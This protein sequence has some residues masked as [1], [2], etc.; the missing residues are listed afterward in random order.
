MLPSTMS[1]F[2]FDVVRIFI[3]QSLSRNPW[4]DY[5]TKLFWVTRKDVI[6]LAASQHLDRNERFRL[7]SLCE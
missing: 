3:H 5:W 7:Y 2:F 4:L 6:S 1:C